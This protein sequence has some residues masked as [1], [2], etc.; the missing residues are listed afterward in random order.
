MESS[1]M[2]ESTKDLM[3]ISHEDAAP[4]QSAS[5]ES[6]RPNTCR[7]CGATLSRTFAD[8]GMSP[9]CESY[10]APEQLN[11]KEPFYPLHVFVCSRCFLVQLQEYVSVDSIFTEYA[12]FS[13]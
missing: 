7:F 13:S 3:T 12:Y 8:L 6:P 4:R 11:Q 2:S 10:L 9:L 1:G 5:S